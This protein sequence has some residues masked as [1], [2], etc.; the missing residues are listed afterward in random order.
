MQVIREFLDNWHYEW[1]HEEFNDL[2]VIEC[3]REVLNAPT[4]EL[5]SYTI[6]SPRWK[7]ELEYSIERYYDLGAENLKFTKTGRIKNCKDR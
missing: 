7:Q 4:T 5:D 2:E 6:N 1:Y 3:F